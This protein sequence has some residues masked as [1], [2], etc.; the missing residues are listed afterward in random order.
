[1]RPSLSQ[2]DMHQR[3]HFG[4]WPGRELPLHSNGSVAP[5]R[6]FSVMLSNFEAA[7]ALLMKAVDLHTGQ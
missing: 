3:Q 2:L 4:R 7:S 5:Q 1:M 6:L